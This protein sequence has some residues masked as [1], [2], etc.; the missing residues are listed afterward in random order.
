M[1][2]PTMPIGCRD[3]P[4]LPCRAVRAS[5]RN[6]LGHAEIFRASFEHGKDSWEALAQYSGDHGPA[7]REGGLTASHP[8]VPVVYEGVG[9]SVLPCFMPVSMNRF[10]HENPYC[11]SGCF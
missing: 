5:L 4:V 6:A 2:G 11:L 9:A 7:Q 3:T 1:L 8:P 10:L